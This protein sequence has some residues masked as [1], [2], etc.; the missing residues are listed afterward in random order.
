MCV[1]LYI[2]Y[3]IY[4]YMSS[5]FYITVGFFSERIKKVKPGSQ[6]KSLIFS[7]QQGGMERHA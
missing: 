1:I 6:R 5:L 7:G 2:M 3:C 4:D